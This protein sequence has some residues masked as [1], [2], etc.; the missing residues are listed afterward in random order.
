MV[1]HLHAV[2]IALGLEGRR[3]SLEEL[4]VLD[5]P[6]LDLVKVPGVGEGRDEEVDVEEDEGNDAHHV[7]DKVH[8]RW[9]RLN[10]LI[11]KLINH[12]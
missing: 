4:R 12:N 11:L 2:A 5:Q 6:F 8:R 3:R 10:Q 9:L 7:K 1:G